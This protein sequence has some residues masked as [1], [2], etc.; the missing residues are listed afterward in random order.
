[1][2]ANDSLL[3]FL[4]SNEM[5]EILALVFGLLR[6][7]LSASNLILFFCILRKMCKR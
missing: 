4:P 1:M 3:G 5:T 7:S 2:S 6:A